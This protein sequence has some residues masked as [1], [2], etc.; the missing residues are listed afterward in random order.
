MTSKIYRFPGPGAS[1]LS[2]EP[3]QL[4][5]P[6]EAGFLRLVR[7]VRIKCAGCR[8]TLA[9]TATTCP[10]CGLERPRHAGQPYPGGKLERY[11]WVFVQ[12]ISSA[13]AKLTLLA[14]VH[15][16]KPGAVAI[17]PSRLRLVEMTDLSLRSVIRALNHL[18]LHGWIIREKRHDRRGQ[19]SSRYV[20]LQA[21][22]LWHELNEVRARGAPR[23]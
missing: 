10:A 17:F 21:E 4:P 23:P 15:H 9:P 11:E 22:T 13:S 6:P 12:T 18:E 2:P 5:F 8:T 16:D 7:P 3:V 14:L 19:T 20:I 1:P